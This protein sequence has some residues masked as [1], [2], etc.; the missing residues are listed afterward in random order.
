MTSIQLIETEIDDPAF[1]KL[2]S[3]FFSHYADLCEQRFVKVIHI[4]NW[5]GERWLGFAGKFKGIAGMRNRSLHTTLPAPPFRPSRVISAYDFNRNS[6]GTYTRSLG[7][8]HTI[9]AEK[10]GG[11]IWDLRYP[12]LYCWY[13]G[14]TLLNTTAVIMIYEVSRQGNNAWYVMFDRAEEWTFT[15]CSNISSEECIKIADDYRNSIGTVEDHSK[16]E[17]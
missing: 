13:S 10:N 4:D 16:T 12:G 3:H 6:D 7:Q 2:A 15:K 14:N 5:F 9:H 17:G 8:F 11:I 1:L